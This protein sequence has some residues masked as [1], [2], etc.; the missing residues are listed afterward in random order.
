[1]LKEAETAIKKHG[2]D[3]TADDEPTQAAPAAEK[4]DKA[5]PAAEPA[6]V[7]PSESNADQFI[8]LDEKGVQALRQTKTLP[9]VEEWN[10]LNNPQRRSLLN[11]ARAQIRASTQQFEQQRT[12]QAPLTG[13][14]AQV[15]QAAATPAVENVPA[16]EQAPQADRFRKV[17]EVLGPE[18]AEVLKGIVAPLEREVA[19][20]RKA[21]EARQNAHYSQLTEA[22]RD[23][24]AKLDPVIGTDDEVWKPIYDYAAR[25]FTATLN[26]GQIVNI[27]KDWPLAIKAS[28]F[29][30]RSVNFQQAA[31]LSLVDKGRRSLA[32]QPVPARREGAA[33]KPLTRREQMIRDGENLGKG[34]SPDQIRRAR[35]A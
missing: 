22:T 19:T 3:V 7:A 20:Y 9:T 29:A 5:P 33:T 31:Q 13:A 34:M 27:D 23:E 6:N 28:L 21:E 10:K 12:M 32:G 11:D 18:A 8:G 15:T 17:E 35:I 14:P 2:A 1:M 24:L 26:M 16:R 30:H 4:T 25:Q